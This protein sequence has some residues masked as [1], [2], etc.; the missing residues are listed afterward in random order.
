MAILISVHGGYL[1]VYQLLN[2]L[3]FYRINGT[4]NTT[5]SLSVLI[6]TDMCT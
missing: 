3:F 6:L 2:E 1:N 5:K 4:P